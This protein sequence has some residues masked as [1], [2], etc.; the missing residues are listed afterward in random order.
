MRVLIVEDDA[1]IA[2]Y[3]AKLV[4]DFGYEVVVSV[5]RDPQLLRK[6]IAVS[7][8][9]ALMDI[10]LADGSGARFFLESI[11]ADCDPPRWGSAFCAR[12]VACQAGEARAR[13]AALRQRAAALQVVASGQ[14]HAIAIFMRR[15]SMTGVTRSCARAPSQ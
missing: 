3:L 5:D 7:P 4:A 11:R 6:A 15:T 8:D 9:V 1:P 12:S 10:R 13:A 2:M 14:P